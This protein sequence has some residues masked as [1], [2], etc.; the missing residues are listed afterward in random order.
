MMCSTDFFSV[1]VMVECRNSLLCTQVLLWLSKNDSV[2]YGSYIYDHTLPCGNQF[3]NKPKTV[4]NSK[5]HSLQSCLMKL[6]FILCPFIF[7]G[8][9]PAISL[10]SAISLK[11]SCHS[12]SLVLTIIFVMIIY[13]KFG[14]GLGIVTWLWDKDYKI[15]MRFNSLKPILQHL[16]FYM[17]WF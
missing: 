7:M 6:Y 17:L 4:S 11:I 12:K 14:L 15:I 10:A 5:S 1:W 13:R 2:I 8:C 9:P 3:V 16:T